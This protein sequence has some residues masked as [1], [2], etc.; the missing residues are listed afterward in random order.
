MDSLDSLIPRVNRIPPTHGLPGGSRG[1]PWDD[2]LPRYL[3]GTAESLN[4][5]AEKAGP[6]G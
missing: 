1:C 6:A 5:G 2:G 4:S 3:R